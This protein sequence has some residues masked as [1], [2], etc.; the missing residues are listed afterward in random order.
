MGLDFYGK[1][2]Q[3]AL[4]SF[5]LTKLAWE[6]EL[7]KRIG[8][9]REGRLAVR[10]DVSPEELAPAFA[11]MHARAAEAASGPT[12]RIP[13]PVGGELPIHVPLRLGS[14]SVGTGAGTLTAGPRSAF[15]TFLGPSMGVTAPGSRGTP[16]A[17]LRSRGELPFSRISN[18]DQLA[19][20]LKHLAAHKALDIE[21][22]QRHPVIRNDPKL[23][24]F[25]L[26]E[27]RKSREA[28]TRSGTYT[29]PGGGA[30]FDP[31]PKIVEPQ[32]K[33]IRPTPS[34]IIKKK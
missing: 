5:G 1:G 20:A 23:M 28:P 34:K 7:L 4:V 10:G 3:D 12:P 29:L 30:G 14:E 15:Q 6:P 2:N 24:Q 33:V 19:E 32:K 22:V 16:S 8:S 13:P 27:M 21:D 26:D 18:K 9:H 25:A 11:A 17:V 31:R